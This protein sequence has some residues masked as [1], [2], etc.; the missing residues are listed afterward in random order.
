MEHSHSTGMALK[1]MSL[2]AVLVL[3]SD[4]RHPFE[5]GMMGVFPV[6]E[7]LSAENSAGT[8]SGTGFSKYGL[9]II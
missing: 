6:F 1:L 4:C 9:Y 2:L 3:A 8:D 5:E 7:L